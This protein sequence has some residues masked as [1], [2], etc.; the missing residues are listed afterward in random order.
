MMLLSSCETRSVDADSFN[1]SSEAVIPAAQNL[2]QNVCVV[3][4]H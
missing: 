1:G 3:S 4:T 2:H